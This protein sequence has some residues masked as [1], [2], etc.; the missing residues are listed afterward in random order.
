LG[1]RPT[2][3]DFFVAPNERPLALTEIYVYFEMFA[4]GPA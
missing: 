3:K 1:I 4:V 2:P